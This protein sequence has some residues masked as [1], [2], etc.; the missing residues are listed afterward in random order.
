[1]SR[2][3]A[4]AAAR[5]GAFTRWAVAIVA[6]LAAVAVRRL[7]GPVLASHAPLLLFT[8]SVMVAARFGGVWPGLLATAF[9][10]IIGSYFFLPPYKSF[11]IGSAADV[12]YLV[13]FVLVGIGISFVSGQ[14]HG[15]QQQLAKI[16]ATA[17]G[18]ICSFRRRSDGSAS[19]PFASPRI[20]DIYGLEPGDLRAS[21][22]PIFEL[23]HPE[24]APHVRASIAESARTMTAWAD[25]FRVR[26]PAKGEIWVEGHSQPARLPDGSIEW[27][28][29]I[30]DVTERHHV[31]QALRDRTA[32]LEELTRTLD[33][34]HAFVRNLDGTITYWSQGA[35]VMYGWSPEEAVGRNSHELLQ[36]E[37]PAPLDGIHEAIFAAGFWQGELRHHHRDGRTVVVASHWALHY[38]DDKKPRSIIEINNDISE[39]K[40]VEAELRAGEEQLRALSASLISIQEEERRRV[41]RELHDDLVQRFGLMAIDLGKL[42]VQAAA[43]ASPLAE[44]LRALQERAVQAAELARHIAHELHPLILDDLGIVTA[45]RSLCD[46]FARREEI[47]VVFTAGD[48]PE[49]IKREVASCLYAVTQESLLNAAKYARATRVEVRL[50]APDI[51]VHL[52]IADDGVGF[53]PGAQTGG[54]GLGIVN[55]RERVRWLKGGFS[56]DSQPGRGTEILV[57]IPL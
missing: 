20:R 50:A 40:R 37:F 1:M 30:R 3:H 52:S 8:L 42:S 36:T 29:F 27:Y 6:V 17:P 45:I 5:W 41:S 38:D 2:N 26:N 16:V 24:D 11:V 10:A 12:G 18:V 33:M 32:R 57:V 34:A 49:A 31:E 22:E 44:E 56:L 7:L 19:F 28:G 39:Q 35:A 47:D 15:A 51:S 23:M 21:A 48:M 55:M 43:A 14:L 9:S 53:P 54:I 4:A 46:E 13:V 25:E